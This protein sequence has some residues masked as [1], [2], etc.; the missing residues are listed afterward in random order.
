M[1]FSELSGQKL[2]EF[3]HKSTN[4]V[5][6]GEAHELQTLTLSPWGLCCC[7]NLLCVVLLLF[8]KIAD[9]AEV[10]EEEGGYNFVLH[11]LIKKIEEISNEEPPNLKNLNLA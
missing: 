3:Y 6:P 5:L 1:G 4:E 8:L 11:S 9:T 10:F 7:D 2:I